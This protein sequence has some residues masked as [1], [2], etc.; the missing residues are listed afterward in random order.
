MPES[1][2]VTV[3][4]FSVTTVPG[5]LAEAPSLDAGGVVSSRVTVDVVLVELQPERAEAVSERAA[6]KAKVVAGV[7][8]MNLGISRPGAGMEVSST[9][10]ACSAARP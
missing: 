10:P 7:R 3:S 6:M 9:G 1:D 8:F 5:L 4:V 2:S